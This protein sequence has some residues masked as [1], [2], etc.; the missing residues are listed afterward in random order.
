MSVP[1][2]ALPTPIGLLAELTHRC[3]LQCVYCSNPLQLAAPATELSTADWKSIFSQAADL[4]V[5]QLHLSGGEPT[6]RR[7]LE[8]LVAHATSLGLYSNLITSAYSLPRARLEALVQAGLAHVQISI[9]GA[10]AGSADVIAGTSGAH[11]R[12]LALAQDVRRLGLALTINAPMHRKNLDQL[13]AIFALAVEA[14]AT[15]L[16][17]AN[18]QYYGWALANRA[19]LM[20][21]REQVK[22]SIDIVKAARARLAGVLAIDFVAPDYYARTPKA[23]MG[24]WGKGIVVVTPGGTVLPC[25]AAETIAGLSFPSIKSQK[26]A[27]IWTHSAAFNAYRGSSWMKDPCRTCDLREVDW[28]GC[29]CQAHAITGDAAEADPVCTKSSFRDRVSEAT[30]EAN[31]VALRYRRFIS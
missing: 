14:G 23:C 24:G 3:P 12:K 11:A 21:T 9:Q 28:G 10:D 1:A 5:L 20:P 17:I 18:V 6:V 26:L 27:D 22:H 31:D 19:A 15:R 29:R 2:P 4:G 8:E 30:R 13:E 16:E 25:H 7:D